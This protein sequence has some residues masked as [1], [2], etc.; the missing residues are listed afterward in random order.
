MK[1]GK[2]NVSIFKI[3]NRRGYAAVCAGHLTE[4]RTGQQAYDRMTKAIRRKKKRTA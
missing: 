1:I 3:K 4:G 2:L